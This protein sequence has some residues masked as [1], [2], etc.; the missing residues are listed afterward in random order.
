MITPLRMV[1]SD[2]SDVGFLETFLIIA[3]IA[4]FVYIVWKGEQE[5][6]NP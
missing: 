3:G 4:I 6:N 1:L 2:V 5:R